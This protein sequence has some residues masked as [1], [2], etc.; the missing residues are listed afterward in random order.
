MR[1]WLTQW[2]SPGTR[3]GWSTLISSSGDREWQLP[4]FVTQ[5][6]F[7]AAAHRAAQ[8]PWVPHN[9][10]ETEHF[11]ASLVKQASCTPFEVSRFPE[12]D[13]WFAATTSVALQP[14]QQRAQSLSQSPE[15]PEVRAASAGRHIGLIFLLLVTLLRWP[16]TALDR[17]FTQG[18]PTVGHA[19]PCRVFACQPSNLWSTEDVLPEGPEDCDK[20]LKALR[21]GPHDDVLV[22]AGVDDEAHGFCGPE[23][24]FLSAV[25]GAWALPGFVPVRHRAR[26]WKEACH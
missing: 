6:I 15:S 2:S 26:Q 12:P 7:G 16:D 25:A 1:T 4:A 8:P 11:K 22:Q 24:T 20:L 13:L 5:R 21:P 3:N 18:F 10:V 14:P 19:P 9:L 17:D 23:M